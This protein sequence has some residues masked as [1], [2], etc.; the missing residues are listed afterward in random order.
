MEKLQNIYDFIV[1][2]EYVNNKYSKLLEIA[3]D[4]LHETVLNDIDTLTNCLAIDMPLEEDGPK[5]KIEEDVVETNNIVLNNNIQLPEDY[6]TKYEI[7]GKYL[8]FAYK[9]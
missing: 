8:P 9:M 2:I 5:I 3:N 4:P 1:Q 6:P 7:E